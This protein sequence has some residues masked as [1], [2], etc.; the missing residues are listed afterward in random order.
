MV[1]LPALSPSL[2]VAVPLVLGL[3]LPQLLPLPPPLTQMAVPPSLIMTDLVR[4][5]TLLSGT[6][7]VYC[8]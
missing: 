1:V 7:Y 8:V 3:L 4:R 6:C 5:S 2:R